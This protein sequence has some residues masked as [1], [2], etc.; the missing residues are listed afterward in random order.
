MRYATK[1]FDKSMKTVHNV[2]SFLRFFLDLLV[3][4][5]FY[6]TFCKLK[7]SLTE[8]FVKGYYTVITG[9][10]LSLMNLSWTFKNPFKI[11][12]GR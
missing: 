9:S 2:F 8:M 12:T 4:G 11:L 3:R 10:I 1:A 7:Q 6:C 5:L